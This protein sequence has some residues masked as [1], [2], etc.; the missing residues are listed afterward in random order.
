M[1]S[2]VSGRVLKILGRP[3][4]GL[5]LEGQAWGTRERVGT[6][7]RGEEAGGDPLGHRQ[8][9]LRGRG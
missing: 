7:G 4:K 2:W 6:T 1:G 3:F 9:R 8:E 5:E